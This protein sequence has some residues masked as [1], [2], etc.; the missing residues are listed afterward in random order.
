MKRVPIDLKNNNKKLAGNDTMMKSL[1]QI[2]ISL[3]NRKYLNRL[4][5]RNFMLHVQ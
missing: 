4:N 3:Y 5:K 1:V 2:L